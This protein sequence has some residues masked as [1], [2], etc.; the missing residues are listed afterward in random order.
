MNDKKEELEKEL[1]E[2]T[3]LL[4]SQLEFELEKDLSSFPQKYVI[5]SMMLLDFHC[6]KNI[7]EEPRKYLMN[8]MVGGI[9]KM[10]IDG[11]TQKEK[12]EICNIL[13]GTV[14]ESLS[15]QENEEDNKSTLIFH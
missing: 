2:L 1:D 11:K 5:L 7:A 8:Q 3:T 12:E 4:R 6:D 13:I 9:T 14:R 15:V 10:M